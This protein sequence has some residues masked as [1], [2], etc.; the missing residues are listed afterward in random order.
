MLGKFNRY[1]TAKSFS[2]RTNMMSAIIMGDDG[3][4]WVVTLARMETLLRTGYEI[5]Y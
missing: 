4:Y 1:A 5:A 2:N 3:K